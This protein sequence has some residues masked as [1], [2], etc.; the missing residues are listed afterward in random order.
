MSED[1]RG[2]FCTY[3][4]EFDEI[5]DDC[6][7]NDDAVEWGVCQKQD[8]VLV[9]WEAN[10]VIHPEKKTWGTTWDWQWDVLSVCVSVFI[11]WAHEEM[12]SSLNAYQGQ[13]W[14]IFS[15]HLDEDRRTIWLLWLLKQSM[16]RSLALM[17][18]EMCLC[19]CTCCT[20]GGGWS[21][22]SHLTG[23]AVMAAVRLDQLAVVTVSYGY[24][25]KMKAGILIILSC[26]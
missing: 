19:S 14:S 13:W 10:T 7:T 2:S 25:D 23:W 4:P 1:K 24:L 17:N 26:I 21:K 11:R 5:L 15:T 18:W 9:V 22:H 12:Q 16:S 6:S 8:K 3:G 20:G